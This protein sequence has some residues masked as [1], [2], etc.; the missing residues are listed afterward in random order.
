MKG[1][2]KFIKIGAGLFV[3]VF[4]LLIVIGMFASDGGSD[5][6]TNDNMADAPGAENI[7]D[8]PVESQQKSGT[9]FDYA[10][11]EYYATRQV[12]LYNTAP[13]GKQYIVVTVHIDNQGT[14]TYNTN[15][16][17]WSLT[18]D[19]VTYDPDVATYDQSIDNKDVDVGPGGKINVQY[20]YL[21]DGN[22]TN[23]VLNYA[24]W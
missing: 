21:V 16:Y 6:A 11:W 18:A 3:G 20:V 23:L 22:P 12:G 15:S 24:G 10:T 8:T 2:M 14:A 9:V 13:A 4:L 7:K 17:K 1:I 19:G 5:P